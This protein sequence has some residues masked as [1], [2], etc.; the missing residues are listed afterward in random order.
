MSSNVRVLIQRTGR[1]DGIAST[2][3][4]KA[5]LI[6]SLAIL[7]QAVIEGRYMTLGNALQASWTRLTKACSGE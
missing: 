1:L 7:H 6:L 3:A 2:R 4:I 5:H